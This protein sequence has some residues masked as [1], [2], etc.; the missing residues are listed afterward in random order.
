MALQPI[1]PNFKQHVLKNISPEERPAIHHFEYDDETARLTANGFTS[2]DLWRIA[3]QKSD[4][5]LWIL[6]GIS[7]VVWKFIGGAD[8]SPSATETSSVTWDSIS[9]KPSTRDGF[10]ISDVYTKTET[11]SLI[12]DIRNF[13]SEIFTNLNIHV[14]TLSTVPNFIISLTLNGVG[15]HEGVDYTKTN[16]EITIS[17]SWDLK[18]N[19][20]ICVTYF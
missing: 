7:P 16:S 3:L 4:T 15:M 13:R 1:K 12:S 18:I 2:S 8:D 11:E 10:A 19:D 5:S 17:N 9:G 14:L 20:A 6:V